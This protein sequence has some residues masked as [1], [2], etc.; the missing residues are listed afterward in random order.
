MPRADRLKAPDG[1]FNIIGAR[2][3]ERRRALKMTQDQ[4]QGRLSLVTE[5]QWA[6][7][8]QEVLNIERG[9]RTVLDVELVALARAL[10]C[11][12]LWLLGLTDPVLSQVQ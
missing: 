11:D 9:I 8:G 1:K 7:S 5:G 2:V 6:I 12:I 3:K 4:L 10:E